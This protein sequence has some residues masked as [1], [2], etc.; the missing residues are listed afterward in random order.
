MIYTHA[1]DLLAKVVALI[2]A[3]VATLAV[4][5]NAWAAPG[6]VLHKVAVVAILLCCA[7]L[8]WLLVWRPVLLPASTWAYVRWT[9]QVSPTWREAHELSRLFA[10]GPA[11]GLRWHPSLDVPSVERQHRLEVLLA[12]GLREHERAR[13]DRRHPRTARSGRH[14]RVQHRGRTGTVHLAHAGHDHRVR[15]LKRLQAKRRVKRKRARIDGPH[16]AHADLVRRR[17]IREPQPP[18][19]I[20]RGREIE[21]DHR[22]Q[23][24]HRDAVH[25]AH[26]PDRF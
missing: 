18:E 6:G 2:L 22:L 7:A 15:R 11:E 20:G 16:P 26:P 24:Q 8:T 23:R 19:H 21:R 10:V 4:D 13:A 12:T 17:A 14:Q 1:F 25:P 9:F 3:L 5:P